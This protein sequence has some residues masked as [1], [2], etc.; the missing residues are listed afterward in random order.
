MEHKLF[1]LQASNVPQPTSEALMH[2]FQQTGDK[3]RP[4][5][6]INPDKVEFLISVSHNMQ[7]IAYQ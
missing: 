1:N 5:I 3:G 7:E 2:E 6:P 4:F